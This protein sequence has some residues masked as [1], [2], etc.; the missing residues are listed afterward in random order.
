MGQHDNGEIYA[1]TARIVLTRKLDTDALMTRAVASRAFDPSVYETNP[2]FFVPVEIS[3]QTRDSY[4]TRM[5]ESTL[6]NFAADAEAGVSVQDSHA[7]DELGFGQSLT[8]RVVTEGDEMRV[9]S[10]Y[11]TVPGLTTRGA[12]RTDDYILG[13][14]AGLYRDV[15]VGFYMGEEGR[16][17]CSICGGDPSDWFG[18]C[19]HWPGGSYDIVNDKGDVTG[20]EVAE[21]WVHNGRLAEYSQ[22]YD[23]ATPGAGV[24]RAQRGI[25]AGKVTPEQALGLERMYRVKLPGAKHI[26]ALSPD[27]REVLTVE[28][29]RDGTAK[30]EVTP[31]EGGESTVAEATVKTPVADVEVVPEETTIEEAPEAE[32]NPEAEEGRVVEAGSPTTDVLAEVRSQFAPKGITIGRDPVVA[33]RV[34]GEAVVRYRDEAKQLRANA[35]IGEQYRLDL[36]EEALVEGV[37]SMPPGKGSLFPSDTYREMMERS[38]TT[39]EQVKAMLESWRMAGNAQFATGRVTREGADESEPSSHREAPDHLHRG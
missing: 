37:R 30:V 21:A 23:G 38:S 34:L 13:I 15:S 29:N 3:N 9:E 27:K 28:T 4:F 22:V 12:K 32:Q 6:K 39:I 33:V 11:F 26:W 36:I 2:P 20:R 25:E 14:R 35:A 1:S 31:V 17:S 16:Y 19:F 8:G 5:H 10:E 24:M 7:T 18:D